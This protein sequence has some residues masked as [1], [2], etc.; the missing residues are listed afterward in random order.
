MRGRRK[1]INT[2][3]PINSR[4]PTADEIRRYVRIM[5]QPDFQIG[6]TLENRTG[7]FVADAFMRRGADG[8]RETS[9]TN[10]FLC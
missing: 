9:V 10:Q 2:I 8:G 5:I 4:W 6:A 1:R 7:A 3:V